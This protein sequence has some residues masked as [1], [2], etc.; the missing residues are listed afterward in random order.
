MSSVS[1]IF[2][3][4]AQKMSY[5]NQKQGVL[6]ENIANVDTPGYRELELKPF[7]FADAM[8]KADMGMTVTDARHIVPAAMAG[9]NA[10]T[11]VAKGNEVQPNGNSVNL[12]GQMMEVSKTAADYQTVVAIYHKM[13]GLFKIAAK[14]SSS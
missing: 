13:T 5:L 9:V 12:E 3:L 10:K 8:K 6:A 14:G 2:D 1:G 11:S 4:L 7:S